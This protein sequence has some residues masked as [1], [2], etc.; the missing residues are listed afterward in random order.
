MKRIITGLATLAA[1]VT[2]S[3]APAVLVGSSAEAASG[4]PGCITKSEFRKVTKKTTIKKARRIIGAK[5]RLSYSNSYSDGD[6]SRSYDFRQCGQR[7]SLSSVSLDFEKTERRVWVSDWY[8]YDGECEDWGGYETKY[9]K[10]FIVT[11][12]YAYWF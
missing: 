7:W 2:L 8:C 5:G 3:V 1:I 11:G 4:T 6:A 12:K 10:P 9:V